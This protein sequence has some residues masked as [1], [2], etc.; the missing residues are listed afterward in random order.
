MIP[1][2]TTY[3]REGDPLVHPFYLYSEFREGVGLVAVFNDRKSDENIEVVLQPTKNYQVCSKFIDKVFAI[4]AP[5]ITSQ[6]VIQY[7]G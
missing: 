7:V 3:T 5:K 2:S 1:F 4:K 6:N